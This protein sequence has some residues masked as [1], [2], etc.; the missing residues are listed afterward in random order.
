MLVLPGT[1][2]IQPTW[3]EFRV[4]E[5][6]PL[7]QGLVAA[8]VPGGAFAMTGRQFFPQW[9]SSAT[10]VSNG[11]EYGGGILSSLVEPGLDSSTL[12]VV[13]RVRLPS[14]PASYPAAGI[15]FYASPTDNFALGFGWDDANNAMMPI[16]RSDSAG[17]GGTAYTHTP[18][19][20]EHLCITVSGW[21]A[22]SANFYRSAASTAT[23]TFTPAG[24]YQSDTR[25]NLALGAG[26][27]VG[28]YVFVYNRVITRE[29]DRL[30]QAAPFDF[31][32]EPSIWVPVSAGGGINASVT[33]TGCS[34]ASAAG[35]T[36][37]LGSATVTLS[38]ASSAS[39]AGSL[40]ATAG[41]TA[42]LS[43]TSSASA[44]GAVAASA[45]ASVT[46]AGSA[47]S[48]AA[49]ALT[50]TAGGNAV[51]TLTG[52]SATSTAG[53][54]TAG[55]S[56]GISLAG[57][58]AAGA[59][60]AVTAT[61]GGA[62]SV[63]LTGASASAAAGILAGFGGAQITLTGA[64]ASGAAGSASAS[65]GSGSGTGATAAEIWS[66]TL[67]NGLT[68]EATVVAIHTKL[69]ELHLIHGLTVGS[70]LS[71]TAASRAAGAVSQAV[72][73]AAGTVTVTR[74]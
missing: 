10:L 17:Y 6:H 42:V 28:A 19:L 56:A 8:I 45:G 71:V 11:L 3:R 32:E 58:G 16:A 7:A 18:P 59:A 63:T 69:S 74:Q 12:S 34:A 43:G 60:G 65:A 20:E 72:A 29:E 62:A 15:T 55:G 54:L 37:A 70:P 13:A 50:A 14:D 44:A 25:K 2:G 24:T 73:E 40:L 46:V 38:G 47:A 52:A 64:S 66:Y 1:G 41:A 68:A 21:G 33:L 5:D 48:S 35:T 9:P 51:A 31:L 30:L 53:S 36:V 22:S 61:A 23:Q 27:L 4:I 67:S 57:V 49:G 39:A 26:L